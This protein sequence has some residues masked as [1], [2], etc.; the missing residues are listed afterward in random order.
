MAKTHRLDHTPF[1]VPPGKP[2]RL[3]NYEPGF[4]SGF[5][6]KAEAQDALLQDV[7]GLVAA[8]DLLWAS[9]QY[10][11]ILIFQA[12]DAAGKDGTI[13]HVMSG[14]NPQGVIVYSFKAP[15]EEERLHH[16]LWRPMRVA[17]ARGQIAIFNRSYYEEVLVVRVHPEFLE[18]QWLPHELHGKELKHVWRSRYDDINAFEEIGH[19]NNTCTIKFFLNVSK[20][21]QRRRFLDRLN[22][23]EKNW[24]FSAADLRERAH[25]DEYQTAYEDMLN[26]T[27]TKTAPWY[28]IPADKKWFT[29]ACVADIITSRIAELD[30]KYP[31]VSEKDRAALAQ[32]KA[33]LEG[34]A[35]S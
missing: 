1:I 2:I 33:E 17:P 19:H 8:Q 27:S 13:K 14:V 30:L 31:E 9:K 4:T 18:Q 3:K 29:R 16:F 32:A 28:V 11:V 7:S 12:L 26:A 5:K 21:E 24:K 15:T 6:D 22:K 20:K 25:W 34:E 23:S 35:E 10:S